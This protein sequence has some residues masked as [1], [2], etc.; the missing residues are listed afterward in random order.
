MR[1]GERGLKQKC[2]VCFKTIRYFDSESPLTTKNP[3]REEMHV[4]KNDIL[5]L[6]EYKASMK[7]RPE[8]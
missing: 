6:I 1:R 4:P 8:P 2:K 3:R 5:K 7:L